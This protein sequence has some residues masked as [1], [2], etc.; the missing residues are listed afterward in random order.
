MLRLERIKSRP[1]ITVNGQGSY[2]SLALGRMLSS[3]NLMFILV[4]HLIAQK[5]KLK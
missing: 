1:A 5:K 3:G 2:E 4:L